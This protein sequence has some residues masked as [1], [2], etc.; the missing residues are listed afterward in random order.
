[1]PEM[2]FFLFNFDAGRAWDKN[3]WV[4]S[5]LQTWKGTWEALLREAEGLKKSIQPVEF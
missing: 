3:H 5:H 2:A 1:M 4:P